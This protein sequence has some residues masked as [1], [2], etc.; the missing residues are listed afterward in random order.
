MCTL[1]L[2]L[3]VLEHERCKEIILSQNN[4]KLLPSGL[5]LVCTL[6]ELAYNARIM[7]A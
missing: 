2:M 5:A 6:N 1:N 7:P 3:I 4:L